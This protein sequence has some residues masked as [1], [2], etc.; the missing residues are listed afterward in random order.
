[1]TASTGWQDKSAW[2]RRIGSDRE[3]RQ[4]GC[5]HSESTSNLVGYAKMHRT[6]LAGLGPHRIARSS[7]SLLPPGPRVPRPSGAR[8]L[9]WR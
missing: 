5:I 1:M 9:G 6:C 8:S 7:S 2:T 3:V 4:W